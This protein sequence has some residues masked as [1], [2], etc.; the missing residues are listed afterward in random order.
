MKIH[1]ILS[2]N[3]LESCDFETHLNYIR[4][5][6]V[7]IIGLGVSNL[8]L[9]DYFYEQKAKVTIFDNKEKAEIPKDIIEKIE[10]YGM[11]YSFGQNYLSKL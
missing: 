8:P 5:R 3:N 9:L 7:A 10:K 2:N 1:F 11:S 6:K 4:Y